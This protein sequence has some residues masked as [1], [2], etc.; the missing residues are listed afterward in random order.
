MLP[1]FNGCIR[2]EGV[3]EMFQY[4]LIEYQISVKVLC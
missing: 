1:L 4:L 3:E 2:H